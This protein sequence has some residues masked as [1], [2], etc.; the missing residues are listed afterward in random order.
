[1]F[2]WLSITYTVVMNTAN[3]LKLLKEMNVFE[4]FKKHSKIL[5]CF[6]NHWK[7]LNILNSK[8]VNNLFEGKLLGEISFVPFLFFDLKLDINLK[9]AESYWQLQEFSL[10]RDVYEKILLFDDENYNVMFRLGEIYNALS[11]YT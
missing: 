5:E 3:K 11:D 1:M 7:V 8:L 6:E 2:Y 9:L 10:A 4:N